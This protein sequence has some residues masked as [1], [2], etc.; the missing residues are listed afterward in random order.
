MK[1]IF[2]SFVFLFAAVIMFAGFQCSSTELTS[3]KLYIQQK[4][5][6]K[7]LDALNKEVEKNPKSDEGYYLL[8]YVYGEK[9]INDKMVDAFDKSLSI[10]KKFEKDIKSAKKSYWANYF[11]KGVGYFNRGVNST[12]EDSI[13]INFD[14]A[15]NSFNQGVLIEP[16]S[17][18]TYKNLAFVYL[19]L[20]DYDKAIPA[21]EKVV[22]LKKSVEGYRYLGDIYYTQGTNLQGTDSVAAVEKFNKAINILEEGRKY[23]PDNSDLLLTLSNSYIGA[24]KIDVAIDAFK[25]GVEKDPTNK[26]Y[27]YNYGVLLLGS[28]NFADAV[29]QFKEA[30]KLDSEYENAIYNLAVTYVKWGARLGKEAEDKGQDL[31]E[32]KVKYTDALPHLEKYC[33]MK[34]DDIPSLELLG[35]VYSVLGMIDKATETFNKVDAL[36]K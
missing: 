33:S 3:A 5:L 10:S 9:E 6:D 20:Q 30:I 15:I 8:G 17:A 36:R 13:K 32:A 31:S 4:N 34:T 29:A 28:N 19:N 21:L 7:A 1:K 35:K 18:D 27:R 11:N 2:N 25:T 22:A 24:N 14:K 23:H 16:D 26:F 12:T